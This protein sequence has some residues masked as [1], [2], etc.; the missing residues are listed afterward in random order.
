MDP[1][2]VTQSFFFHSSLKILVYLLS[3]TVQGI[4]AV[5]FPDGTHCFRG[6]CGSSRYAAMKAVTSLKAKW[7]GAKGLSEAY[8]LLIMNPGCKPDNCLL[9]CL[10][11]MFV[12]RNPKAPNQ[13]TWE[14]LPYDATV[15]HS[16]IH[17]LFSL[18]KGIAG[19]N[20]L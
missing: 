20:P 1:N 13:A 19:L 14:V 15:K 5:L 10:S 6:S 9:R 17:P 18:R 11:L 16:P 12:W 3:I 2:P 8:T 7:H 4:C